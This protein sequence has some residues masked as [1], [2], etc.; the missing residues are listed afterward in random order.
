[1]EAAGGRKPG[2]GRCSSQPP[3]L[4]L[5]PRFTCE[6]GGTPTQHSVQDYYEDQI[7][8]EDETTLQQVSTLQKKLRVSCLLTGLPWETRHFW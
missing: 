6:M 7:D 5:S 2:V 8:D 1:M 3:N 4:G